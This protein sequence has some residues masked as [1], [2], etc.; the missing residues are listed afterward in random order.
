MVDWGGHKQRDSALHKHVDS[1]QKV[2]G[3]LDG[4][5]LRKIQTQNTF[6]MK[7]GKEKKDIKKS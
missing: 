7:Q 3:N 2:T 1:S 6:E 5:E 4:Q